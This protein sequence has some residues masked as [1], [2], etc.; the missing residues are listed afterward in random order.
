MDVSVN[1][2]RELAA[3]LDETPEGL[4]ERLSMR[5][6]PVDGVRHVG[7]GLE[8]IL[9]ARV[10]EVQPHPNADRLSFCRID[11]GSGASIEL[12]CGA[13]VV[14]EGALYAWVPPGA[15]LPGG[16]KIEAREIRGVKSHGMLCSEYE[17]TL[18]RDR[19]GILRLPSDLDPGR[20][21]AEALGLPDAVLMLDLTPNRVDLACH[22][23]VARELIEVGDAG[24]RLREFG[25]DWSPA[26]RD[27]GSE[28]EVAG[29]RVAI[30]DRE[31]CSRYLGA[32]I[33]G[34]RIGASPAWLAGRLW[35]VGLRPINNVVDATNYIL[36]E[37]NQPL[38]AF[39][40]AKLRGAEIRVRAARSGEGL[41]TLDGELRKLDT[42]ATVIADAEGPVALAG[43]M[44]GEESEVTGETR[45]VFLECAAFDPQH[46]RRTARTA[47]ISTDASY[48][49]ER[50]IDE[51]GLE[52][53]LR[54]CVELVLAV[55]GG[56]AATEAAR[57]GG[58]PP[59]RTVVGLRPSRVHHLLG[60]APSG[61][62]L[63][64]Q[65]EPLGFEVLGDEG[66]EGELRVLVP[67]WR[68]DVTRE[69]DLLEE[70]ARRHG[71]ENF[72][73]ET[74]SFR[75]SS[76]SEDPVWTRGRRVRGLFTA[77]GFLE[78]RSSSFVPE[79]QPGG[80]ASVRLRNPLSAE[81][82]FLRAG[83]VPVLLRR[84]EHNWAR[85]RREVR[86]FEIG[87]VF[88][89]GPPDASGRERF[90][91]EIR[92]GAVLTGLRYPA[93]W[94]R[95]AEDADVWDLKGLAAEVAA[96]LTA[97]VLEP[98]E[99][100][101]AD[102]DDSERASELIDADWLSP[103]GFRILSEGHV[104]GLA[105][106]VREIAVDAPPWAAPVWALEFRLDAVRPTAAGRY[107]PVA[108]YPVV[109]RDLALTVPRQIPAASV[110][111]E[112]REAAAEI[113]ESLSL[114]DLYEGSGIE[115]ERRSLA[116]ALRFRAAD[117]TLT[118]EEVEGVMCRILTALEERF[119][120][121]VRTS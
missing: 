2:L 79:E 101:E 15:T 58:E 4:A 37:R 54:R 121:H 82:G 72:P 31:R 108:P 45:D 60:I 112:I 66:E 88:S 67:G 25:S 115:R 97:G 18:G 32:V 27:G 43:V 6:V 3:G 103:G 76:V 77:R 83:M 23:G 94:S 81:E 74:R 19:S 30:E 62:E 12:V 86:L 105:G 91:E 7:R 26:W 14:E 47:G 85:G 64:Q 99:A 35:A 44:G 39:D 9:V 38:H 69:V 110:E 68:R 109:R 65:L 116:W 1:W 78:A 95:E 93:H 46:T 75:P 59:E 11:P 107:A 48:R 53:A 8:S 63:R 113:L 117:R 34:V 41:R 100:R 106:S 98:V 87:T 120:A 80:R 61:V 119:D 13:P 84:L 73:D 29:I 33:R 42:A 52:D 114:F 111:A 104:V 89:L 16:M 56:E 96:A 102:A 49:F 20:P 70:V 21:L 5:A 118:D 22:V 57:A 90:R 71:Y 50:G 17:L 36:L 51:R 40:L 24:I 92:V 10:L 55:A 28:A